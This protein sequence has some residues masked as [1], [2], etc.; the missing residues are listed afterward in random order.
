MRLVQIGTVF[1]Y[2]FCANKLLPSNS[3]AENDYCFC[4]K[5]FLHIRTIIVV[6]KLKPC[7]S[8]LNILLCLSA[9]APTRYNIKSNYSSADI[10]SPGHVCI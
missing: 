6:F 3:L 10:R 8:R 9:S 5:R 4:S 2:F 1:F 7:P